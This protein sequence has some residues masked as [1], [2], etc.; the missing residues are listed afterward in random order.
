MSKLLR[1]SLS[2]VAARYRQFNRTDRWC[3]RLAA[4]WRRFETQRPPTLLDFILP[5][6]VS[7]YLPVCCC[8]CWWRRRHHHHET[9]TM[10]TKGMEM[11]SEC[12]RCRFELRA[13]EQQDGCDDDCFWPGDTTATAT[14]AGC[15]GAGAG[16]DDPENSKDRRKSCTIKRRRKRRSSLLSHRCHQ[17]QQQ[18][19]H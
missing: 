18:Q 13:S 10:T 2:A 12:Y 6:V 9:A 15:G 5:R 17:R 16:P 11:S 4:N 8:C 14:T 19:Q 7:R 3:V 1:L